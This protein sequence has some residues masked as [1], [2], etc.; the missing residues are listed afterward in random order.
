MFQV[1]LRK[2]RTPKFSQNAL[3]SLTSYSLL[4]W[5]MFSKLSQLEDPPQ[6]L[7]LNIQVYGPHSAQSE[8]EE[9]W[10]MYF[11]ISTPGNFYV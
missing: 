1:R 2:T 5:T 6:A 7:N 11:L 8:W 10:N 9:P 3:A 4:P